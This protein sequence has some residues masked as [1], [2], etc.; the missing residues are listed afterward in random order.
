MLSRTKE[1][2]MDKATNMMRDV[3]KY[4]QEAAQDKRL[5]ADFSDALDHGSKASD[6]LKKDIQ[7]GSIY[8]R[9]AAD[10]KLRK[11]LRAM[12]DDLDNAGN[13]MRRKKSHRARN[14]LLV[15]AGGAAAL[16]ALPK[17]RPWL[18]ERKSQIVGTASPEPETVT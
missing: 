9:L 14:V 2:H 4:A 3:V 11:N 18:A 15:F 10:K 8:T 1:S 16:V 17:V 13:R 6:R 5:R 12:L 7:A